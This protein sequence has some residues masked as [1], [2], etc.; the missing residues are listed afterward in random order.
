MTIR[1]NDPNSDFW[2]AVAEASRRADAFP[3]WKRG[4][5]AAPVGIALQRR[6]VVLE[7][8]RADELAQLE[9]LAGSQL[10]RAQ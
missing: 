5:E 2:K 9:L 10:Q 1:K 7:R 3:P 4:T 8:V 6:H